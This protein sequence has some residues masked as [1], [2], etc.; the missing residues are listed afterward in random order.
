[1]SPVP[2]Y[3]FLFLLSCEEGK[4]RSHQCLVLQ[5][6]SPKYLIKSS[7]LHLSNC[8]S[9]FIAHEYL[10]TWKTWLTQDMNTSLRHII[11]IIITIIIHMKLQYH[12]Y[13][14]QS[15]LYYPMVIFTKSQECSWEGGRWVHTV[16]SPSLWAPA[17]LNWR[18]RRIMGKRTNNS[19]EPQAFYV[20]QFIGSKQ[21]HGK[22]LKCLSL[23]INIYISVYD[24]LMEE[25]W[26]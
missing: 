6:K 26:L 13:S 8:Q 3:H 14:Y 1:M 17:V 16:V 15:L 18:K 23:Y 4:E 12:S 7:I 11:I 2:T 10:T 19:T 24:G 9:Y 20:S 21:R 22:T 5:E 25:A